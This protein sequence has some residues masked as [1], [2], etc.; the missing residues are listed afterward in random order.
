M[1]LD[2][3]IDDQIEA[4]RAADELARLRAIAVAAEELIKVL[5]DIATGL[6]QE[7]EGCSC[8]MGFAPNG[9]PYHSVVC[10]EQMSILA[11]R[12][13]AEYKT[14]ASLT[15]ESNNGHENLYTL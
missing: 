11:R 14:N 8:E 12:T 2:E 15:P 10:S 1:T 3:I 4:S 13:I 9:E 7:G 6:E 5:D